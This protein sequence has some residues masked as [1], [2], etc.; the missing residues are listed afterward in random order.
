MK[1]STVNDSRMEREEIEVV[2]DRRM[3]ETNSLEIEKTGSK[4]P[5]GWRA[6]K[7]GGEQAE[8]SEGD[9]GKLCSQPGRF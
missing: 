7:T 1:D 5:E 4:L 2:S 3:E 6:Q 8:S 9:P